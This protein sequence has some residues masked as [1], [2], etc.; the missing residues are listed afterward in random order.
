MVERF[1]VTTMSNETQQG[2]GTIMMS[3]TG[4]S[5][6]AMRPGPIQLPEQLP[7][8]PLYVFGYGSLLWRPGFTYEW[9]AK[10]RIHGFHRALRVWSY[11]HRGTEH[12]PGLVLGL[13]AGGSCQGGVFEATEQRKPAV[14]Q[15][16]WEREMVTSVYTP[17][18]VRAHCQGQAYL[19]LTFVLDRHHTQYAGELSA[20]QA[21]GHIETA[22]GRSGPNPEYLRETLAQL[23][24]LN[25]HDSGL[26]AVLYALERR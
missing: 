26:E 23:N 18:L 9:T 8:G 19:A 24:A 12:Q 10:A 13:D 11:H 5:V 4:E 7:P 15:Y 2:A 17:R 25:V 22:V 6:R 16:L 3:S 14:A 21:A 1:T 20:E